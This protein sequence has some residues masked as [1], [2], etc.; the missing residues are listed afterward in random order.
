MKPF[1]DKDFLLN[2]ETAKKLFH[3]AAESCPIIDYHCHINPREIFED[4]QYESIT[5]VWLGGDH[6]KWRLMRLSGVSEKFITGDAS[7]HDK[8]LAW[9]KVI[10][11]GIGNPLYHWS[12][13]ELRRFFNYEGVLNEKTAEEVWKIANEKL[14]QSNFGVRDLIRMSNVE[15]I[16]TTDDPVDNLEWHEKLAADKTFKTAVLP[17]WRPDKAMN[18]EKPTWPEYIAKLSEVSGV[19]IDSFAK[20]KEALKIRMDYFEKHGCK[21]SDHGLDYVMYAPASEDEIEAIFKARVEG[22]IPDFDAAAKFKMAF[23]IFVAKE[24][25]ARNWVMQLHYGCRRDNNEPMFNKLGP[26]TGFDCVTNTAPST[27]TAAFLGELQKTNELPKT[28][29]YSLNGNDNST[30]DTM[31]GC[32]QSDE[33]VSKIQHGSA[34]WFED[35]LDG[36]TNQMKSLASLGYLAG[37]VGMLTDSRSF[38]SYPRHELFRRIL[39]RIL[40]EWVEEGLYPDDMETLKSIVQD[41]SYYNAKKYFNFAEKK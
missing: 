37:F 35:H 38:L 14:H 24:Y 21:L 16:C 40:C 30:I 31:A 17:A 41:I 11:R 28:I 2:T 33:A 5:K 26:D 36:M 13:L 34:W 12:H 6:Y 1:M 15:T 19:K 8:F 32:F 4:R 3:E 18:L 27:E 22:K 29:L 10:G 23:M 9:A 39:C 20:L 7:D 25:H